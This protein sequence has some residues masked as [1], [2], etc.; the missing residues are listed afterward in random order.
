MTVWSVS[1]DGDD[2]HACDVSECH[3]LRAGEFLSLEG[4]L[5]CSIERLTKRRDAVERALSKRHAQL[6]QLRNPL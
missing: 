5:A 3:I 2:V 1:L 4:A 6:F